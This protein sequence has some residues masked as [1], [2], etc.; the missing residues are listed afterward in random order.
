MSDAA[1]R[2]TGDADRR[3]FEDS[4]YMGCDRRPQQPSD[5]WRFNSDPP[6]SQ[7]VASSSAAMVLAFDCSYG[8]SNYSAIPTSYPLY[9]MP[10][11]RGLQTDWMADPSA[12]SWFPGTV[13][14]KVFTTLIDS[15]I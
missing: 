1:D 11:G 13:P 6:A 2:E 8:A 12:D 9:Q 10:R 14:C 5:S 7:P 4:N 15:E 3:T